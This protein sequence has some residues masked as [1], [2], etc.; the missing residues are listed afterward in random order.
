MIQWDYDMGVLTTEVHRSV[1]ERVQCR[2]LEGVGRWMRLMSVSSQ[3]V[4]C[5]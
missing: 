3:L 1:K 2:S 5:C 4:Y